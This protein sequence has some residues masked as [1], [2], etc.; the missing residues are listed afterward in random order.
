MNFKDLMKYKRQ[1]KSSSTLG[2]LPDTFYE[3]VEKYCKDLKDKND[4]N[5]LSN[6]LSTVDFIKTT[7]LNKLFNKSLYYLHHQ[8]DLD[9]VVENNPNLLSLEAALYIKILKSLYEY[10]KYILEECEYLR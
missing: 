4:Y 8:I 2:L 7:R 6:V 3:D 1:E 5:T 9:E 10:N